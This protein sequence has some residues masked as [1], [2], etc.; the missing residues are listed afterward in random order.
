MGAWSRGSTTTQVRRCSPRSPD[1]PHSRSSA[2]RWGPRSACR[3]PRCGAPP[4]VWSKPATP[5][6]AAS[7]ATSTTEPSSGCSRS[8]W[9]SSEPV[10]ARERIATLRHDLRRV[11]HGIHSVTL[12]EGGLS[13][14][15]LALVDAASG[16]VAVESLPERRVA[17]A[18]EAAIYRLVAAAL[19]LG[20]PTRLAIDAGDDEL[21][22]TVSVGGADDSTLA[23]ALAHAGAR[24]AALGGE[25]TVT[26]AT[27]RARVPASGHAPTAAA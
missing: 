14:A 1:P 12:A 25:I 18:A 23:G 4:P 16:R 13:E 24:I 8:A 3:R 11:A 21:R 20:H 10:C 19:R 7:S 22:A 26:G 17:P 15:V 27:A 5:S 2:R 6:D 9:R